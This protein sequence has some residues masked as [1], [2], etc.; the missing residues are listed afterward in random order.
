M[1]VCFMVPTLVLWYVWG[2]NL[3]NSYFLAF[4]SLI[5]HCPQWHLAGQW[6]CP[7]VWKVALWQEYQPSAKLTR[8]L[9]AI[10]EW[11]LEASEGMA[12]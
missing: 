3:W 1:L 9:G 12:V 8:H 4:R 5:R 2:E 6:R 7:H 10:G 11:V